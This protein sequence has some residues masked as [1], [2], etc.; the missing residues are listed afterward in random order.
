[1]GGGREEG[2]GRRGEG[3]EE[4]GEEEEGEKRRVPFCCMSGVGL[5][6]CV[7]EEN[8]EREIGCLWSRLTDH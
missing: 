3:E 1:M 7:G 2:G 5:F 8:T 6:Q 4:E